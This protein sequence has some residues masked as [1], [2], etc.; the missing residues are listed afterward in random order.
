MPAAARCVPHSPRTS[1]SRRLNES[2]V[3]CGFRLLLLAKRR[4]DSTAATASV[5]KS[6]SASN[7]PNT[8]QNYVVNLSGRAGGLVAWLL[9]V[10]GISRVRFRKILFIT[11]LVLRYVLIEFKVRAGHN[12]P[13]LNLPIS[14]V[15]R[16]LPAAGLRQPRVYGQAP[17]ASGM[18]RRPPDP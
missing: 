11:V 12:W 10:I 2:C 6:R 15:A 7:G 17:S 8:D 13:L 5:I 14:V 18:H 4:E 3:R 16:T 9:S 1:S